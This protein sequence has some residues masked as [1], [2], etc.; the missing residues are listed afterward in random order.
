MD[1]AEAPRPIRRLDPLDLDA[2][3]AAI[4][5]A[6]LASGEPDDEEVRVLRRLDP[7]PRAVQRRTRRERPLLGQPALALLRERDRRDALAARE[8]RQEPLR[9]LRRARE[10]D[11][12]ARERM[13]EERHRRRMRPER[14]G[15][16]RE[17]ED[18]EL[19]A[20]VLGRQMDPG[21]TELCEALPEDGIEADLV[22]EELAQARHRTLIVEELG[23]GLLQH[24]LLVG[25]IEIHA[26]LLRS[27][28][29]S[30]GSPR[31]RSA[32]TLRWTLA[33]P[34]AIA[35]PTVAM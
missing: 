8:R 11:R 1:P 7:L 14:L 28:A 31:P 17:I 16:D 20:A 15:D 3:R 27:A 25:E 23:D 24:P 10:R 13:G 35:I 5:D 6:E 21:D 18:L 9:L 4:D 32:M 33:V 30:R 19:A 26:H 34:P 12:E 22:V 2:L 29:T